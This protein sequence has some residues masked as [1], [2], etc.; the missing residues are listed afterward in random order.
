VLRRAQA[1]Y[2][3]WLAHAQFYQN[4]YPFQNADLELH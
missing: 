2:E 1:W 3:D 4:R